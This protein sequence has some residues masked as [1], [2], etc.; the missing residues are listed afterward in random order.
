MYYVID[1]IVVN[2]TDSIIHDSKIERNNVNFFQSND[3]GN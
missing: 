1:I 2:S 3:I